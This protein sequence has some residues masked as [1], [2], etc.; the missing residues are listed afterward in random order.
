MVLPRL[1]MNENDEDDKEEQR[2]VNA[3]T[4]SSVSQNKGPIDGRPPPT[5][6]YRTTDI[7]PIDETI[8]NEAQ[9]LLGGNDQITSLIPEILSNDPSISLEI[10]RHSNPKEPANRYRAITN[11]RKAFFYLGLT[12]T[13]EI[14]N[15]CADNQSVL[16]PQAEKEFGVL[17]QQA[18]I[19]GNLTAI[20]ARY[21]YPHL[22][23]EAKILGT[24]SNL[25]LMIAC[26]KFPKQFI[27]LSRSIPKSILKFKINNHLP[28]N[29]ELEQRR[30]LLRNN[31]PQ[32]LLG[33][34][35]DE[36]RS[37][38]TSENHLRLTTQAGREICSAYEKNKLQRYSSPDELPPGSM[39]RIL[40]LSP[41]TYDNL[42]RDLMSYLK[43]PKNISK[44]TLDN[45][46]SL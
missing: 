18:V 41:S 13:R 21:V 10:L 2:L 34:L 15:K 38:S 23:D 8:L 3:E 11:L 39:L 25:K 26:L 14:I 43:S 44:T 36:M 24:F 28:Y 7:L 16:E 46:T 31:L 17:R 42:Y 30:F 1:F 33:C 9:T 35:D 45:E 19:C 29:L 20:I 32:I 4:N 5:G 6:I 37:N 40:N 27:H 22:V 12:R